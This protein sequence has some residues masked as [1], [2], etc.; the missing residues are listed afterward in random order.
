[1]DAYDHAKRL[2]NS[3]F[4]LCIRN[5]A[6]FCHAHKK[7]EA[8]ACGAYK[9]NFVAFCFWYIRYRSIAYVC[10]SKILSD[11]FR[12]FPSS[13]SFMVP[14]EYLCIRTPAFANLLLFEDIKYLEE[15]E[16]KVVLSEINIE[17]LATSLASIDQEFYQQ[18]HNSNN[19]LL[20]ILSINAEYYR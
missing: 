11:A 10:F 4:I 6:L 18:K 12:L 9:T 14:W 8:I 19:H 5:G 13:R 17:L 16:L 7:L 1:M 20:I 3:I 2:A 15:E